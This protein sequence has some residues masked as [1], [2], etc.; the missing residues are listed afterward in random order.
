[1]TPFF[2]F[3]IRVALGIGF[4]VL[5]MRLFYRDAGPIA[6]LGVAAILVGMAYI[7][8]NFRKWQRDKEQGD[9]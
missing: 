5:V 2:I 9:R 7:F 1:M 6:V 4:A 3:I 8:E